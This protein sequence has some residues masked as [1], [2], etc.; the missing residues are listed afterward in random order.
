[1]RY[2][3]DFRLNCQLSALRGARSGYRPAARVLRGPSTI[4][5][6][7]KTNKRQ[8]I[9]E[10]VRGFPKRWNHSD[11]SFANLPPLRS[12]LVTVGRTGEALQSPLQTFGKHGKPLPAPV[13]SCPVLSCSVL[14][15][16]PRTRTRIRTS[17][18]VLGLPGFRF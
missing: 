10:I 8:I 5:F 7:K 3:K 18:F 14:F 6:Q 12:V 11:P 4:L 9:E 15:C 13:L 1:M 2:A 17:V 16:P